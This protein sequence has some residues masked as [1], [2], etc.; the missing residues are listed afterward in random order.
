M[1]P[2]YLKAFAVAVGLSA[3]IAPA[4]AAT[5]TF[6]DIVVGSPNNIQ[7][8]VVS[9]GFNFTGPHFHIIDS[10]TTCSTGCVSDGTQYMGED[11]G[12][13]VTMTP[14]G[15]GL[16]SLTSFEGAELFLGLSNASTIRIYGHLFGG[17]NVFADLFL[18]GLKDGAGG[19][20]DFQTF[21]IGWTNL[22]SVDF[23]GLGVDANAISFSVD[24]IV[25]N[26]A[27]PEPFTLWLFGAGL[28]GAVAMRRRKAAS[29]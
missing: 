9:G 2:S 28:A 18:D 22:T 27:V 13:G 4:Q 19:I 15:G 14:V 23:V 11:A 3:M 26:T 5:I 29:A 20:P 8:G 17:S 10:P 6:D 7:T 24:N 16:F 1:K 21:G 25:V 12:N